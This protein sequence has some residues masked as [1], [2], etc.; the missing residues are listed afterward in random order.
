MQI[1]N[2]APLS[3]FKIPSGTHTPYAYVLPPVQDSSYRTKISRGNAWQKNE[4]YRPLSLS[5]SLSGNRG[6]P[7][8][9]CSLMPLQDS[10]YTHF[11]RLFHSSS[12]R[13]RTGNPNP[14]LRKKCSVVICSNIFTNVAGKQSHIVARRKE[15]SMGNA[16]MRH[17]TLC[18]QIKLNDQNIRMEL[19]YI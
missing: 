12:K 19:A 8:T 1:I 11:H 15:P 2:P 18:K 16:H 6:T 4:L 3:P 9:A 14:L 13:T 17:I 10:Q 7:F 5:L